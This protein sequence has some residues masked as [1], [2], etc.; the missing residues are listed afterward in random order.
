M[1]TVGHAAQV[2]LIAPP[3]FAAV[4]L[5][6]R[7]ALY[8]LI[9]SALSMLALGLCGLHRLDLDG[10]AGDPA[11]AYRAGHA[12]LP[13]RRRHDCG[14]RRRAPAAACRVA[15][16]P[17]P[18][19]GLARRRQGRAL[20]RPTRNCAWPPQPLPNSTT[21]S[22]S[23][24][25][26][27]GRASRSRSFSPTMPWYG[28]SGYARE[29]LL[30]NTIGMFIGP[31]SDPV[32]VARVVDAMARGEGVSVELQA[33]TKCATPLLAR[34]RCGSVPRRAGPAHPLGRH[35]PRR[36]RAQE[37][38]GGHRPPRLLRC[39]DRLAEPASVHGNARAPAGARQPERRPAVR[40]PRPLQERQRRARPCHRRQPAQAC[41]RPAC[42]A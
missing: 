34:A 30:G 17:A 4:L 38:R 22:S 19:R 42:R 16:R 41:R 18:V 23:R 28:A 2:F 6:M 10:F 15:G 40:R 8:T 26:Q 3:V 7:P 25:S 20:G 21:T 37:S 29:E 32:Q 13:V 11:L 33:Y 39:P 27:P 12:Q 14:V 35:R 36:R 31:Q 5:G 24:A 1:L 9:A